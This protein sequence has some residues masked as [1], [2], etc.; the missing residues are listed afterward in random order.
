MRPVVCC[1]EEIIMSQAIAPH[2]KPTKILLPID[3]SSSS[4]AALE[5]AAEIAGH[6]Q[7]ELYLL[8]V[9]PKLPIVR[10]MKQLREENIRPKQ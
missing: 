10:Q 8:H 2:F 9:I 5:T 6:F 4:C 3:F 7:A 1:D